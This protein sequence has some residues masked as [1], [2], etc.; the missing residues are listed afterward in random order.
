MSGHK[1]IFFKVRT[2]TSGR[3]MEAFGST[4]KKYC[5]GKTIAFLLPLALLPS[6]GCD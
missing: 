5:L 4:D 3:D 6:S 1:E 2:E